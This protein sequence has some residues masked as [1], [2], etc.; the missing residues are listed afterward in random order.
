[1]LTGPAVASAP[2]KV[3]ERLRYL[4]NLKVLL[5]AGVI[6]GHAWAG[7]DQ[8]GGWVYTQARE[9]S[10]AAVTRLLA[11]ALLGPFGLFAMGVFFLIAGMLT[12]NSLRRK[13]S[14]R[15]ARDRLLRLGLPLAVFTIVVWPPVR[16]LLDH[17]APLGQQVSWRWP[18]A[19]FSYLWFLVV[20][21]VFSL[22]AAGWYGLRPFPSGD[23]RHEMGLAR[24]ACIAHL[25]GNRWRRP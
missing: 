15:F 19:D 8:I 23:L 1:M 13:G 17:L 22:G 6:F 20:L 10:V 2:P 5:V 9:V 12:P 16:Y 21:L 7:Y 14:A 18:S 4:D 11:E 25:R 24:L 3:V